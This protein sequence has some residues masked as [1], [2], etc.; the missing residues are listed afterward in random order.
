MITYAI[1]NNKGGTGKT[2]LTFQTVCR[3]AQKHPESRILVIDM[4]PQANL[5]EVMLGGVV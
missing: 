1:W 5:S 2:T 4:C 3:Y